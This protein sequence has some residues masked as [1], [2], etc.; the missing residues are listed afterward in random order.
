L[1]DKGHGYYLFTDR[2]SRIKHVGEGVLNRDSHCYCFHG[3]HWILTNSYPDQ[4]SMQTLLI[5]DLAEDRRY[6]LGRFYSPPTLRDEIRCDLHPRWIPDGCQIC[7]DSAHTAERQ[8]YV[9]NVA[10]IVELA[11]T[12]GLQRKSAR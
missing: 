5:Y 7:F 12:G 10:D 1:P 8:I 3:G 6:N 11:A 9:I 4:E 2:R